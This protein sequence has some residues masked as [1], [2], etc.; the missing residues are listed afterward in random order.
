MRDPK[1][2]VAGQ[3]D[4]SA[5]KSKKFIYSM[6]GLVCVMIVWAVAVY[7][8]YKKSEIST[9]LIDLSKLVITFIATITV[10]LLGSHSLETFKALG[11]ISEVDR[12]DANE[13]VSKNVA[14]NTIT[15][16]E[17]TITKK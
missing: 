9:P 3:L 10:T 17:T 11:T 14:S 4:K 16:T 5:L 1:E 2:Y 13:T 7:T 12:N 15:A 6:I 8:M